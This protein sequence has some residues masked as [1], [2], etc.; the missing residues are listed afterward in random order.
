M[1]GQVYKNCYCC[2]SNE[3]VWDVDIDT[4]S[5]DLEINGIIH[6]YHCKKCGAQISVIAPFKE[7]EVAENE[8]KD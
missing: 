6:E 8:S 4:G 2:G 3:I 5:Q 1:S 7:S